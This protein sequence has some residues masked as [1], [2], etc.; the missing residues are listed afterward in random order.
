MIHN[1]FKCLLSPGLHKNYYGGH[2][3]VS[4]IRK[5]NLV[6][7]MHEYRP[8]L[9][10]SLLLEK[11]IQ[12]NV[13]I[14]KGNFIWHSIFFFCLLPLW[15]QIVEIKLDIESEL[16]LMFSVTNVNISMDKLFLPT[17][18]LSGISE[19]L[20]LTDSEKER[21]KVGG[22]DSKLLKSYQ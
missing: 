1:A 7:S 3:Q 8:Q 15:R 9:P 6:F 22:D 16:N 13:L 4:I 2:C 10:H 18:I 21:W 5:H 11:E 12:I 17:S 14:V 19:G 20:N